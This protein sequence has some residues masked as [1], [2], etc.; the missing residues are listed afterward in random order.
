[1]RSLIS[2]RSREPIE[3]VCALGWASARLQ[4]YRSLDG[5]RELVGRVRLRTSGELCNPE[6]RVFP[7]Q[8]AGAADIRAAAL[9]MLPARSP[10]GR[11]VP[12]FGNRLGL[13]IPED[14]PTIE[15][16]A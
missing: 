3:G 10:V 9:Q 13:Q 14:G 1:M 2:A 4:L 16:G 15:I 8:I 5:R 12:D 6:R 7:G 11:S